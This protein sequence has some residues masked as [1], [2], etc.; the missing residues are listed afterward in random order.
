MDPDVRSFAQ[1]MS[2]LVPSL[3]VLIA[4]VVVSIKVIWRSKLPPA[5]RPSRI[6]DDRF[7]RLE[8]AVDSIA[9]EVERIS[10]SQRF[11]VKLLAERNAESTPERASRPNAS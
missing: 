5:A 2:I 3:V 10:E 9:I 7:E 8:Q 6:D 11:A 4:T 1:V